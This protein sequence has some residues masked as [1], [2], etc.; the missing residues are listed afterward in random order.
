MPKPNGLTLKTSTEI[1]SAYGFRVVKNESKFRPTNVSISFSIQKIIKEDSGACRLL[2]WP[3]SREEVKAAAAVL[4]EASQ[5][6]QFA[7]LQMNKQLT[8]NEFE[9]F[10]FRA[11]SYLFDRRR[12][13][14]AIRSEEYRRR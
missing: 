13:K 11:V 14:A 3:L 12:E 6:K 7:S 8:D 9:A 4:G 10:K 1:L 2:Y 5:G